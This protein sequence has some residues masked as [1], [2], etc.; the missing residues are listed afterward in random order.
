MI[1][2]VN[3]SLFYQNKE[4]LK[5]INLQIS[6]PQNIGIIGRSGSGKSLFAKSLIGLFD[7]K[8]SP[9]A[10]KFSV[11]G[12]DILSFKQDKLRNFR[13]KVGLLFQNATASFPPL[14]NFGDIFLMSLREIF[15]GDIKTVKEVSFRALKMVGLDD[16][17][18]IWHKFP[19]QISSGMASR[20]QLALGLCFEPKLLI[21][22]EIT[23]GLDAVNKSLVVSILKG[24]K[25][26][27]IIIT[28]EPQ[29]VANLANFVIVF[30]NGKIVEQNSTIEIFKHPQNLLTKEILNV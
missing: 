21:Y 30:D 18:L 27:K 11:L 26:P 25:T 24:I 1:D 19:Y 5:N 4:L 3:F 2:I 22:D 20:V 12:S 7:D 17:N 23:S 6:T 9:K 28:H 14:Y 29:I 13:R 8:F 16:L 10:D 15:G